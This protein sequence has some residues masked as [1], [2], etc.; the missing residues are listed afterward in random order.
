MD[1]T[2]VPYPA[3]FCVYQGNSVLALLD[4]GEGDILYGV[5]GASKMF[6]QNAAPAVIGHTAIDTRLVVINAETEVFRL[7]YVL[8]VADIAGDAINH[9]FTRTI[10]RF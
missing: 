4:D 7:T 5:V 6:I 2:K 9:E 8:L 10:Y 3:T 1:T